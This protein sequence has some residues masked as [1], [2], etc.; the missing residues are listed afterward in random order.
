MIQNLSYDFSGNLLNSLKTLFPHPITQKMT[1]VEVGCFE[2]QGSM[3]LCKKL[4]TQSESILICIDPFDEEYV[5]GSKEM[6]FWDN[7]CKGQY[8]R[9]V[10]NTQGL[11]IKVLRGKSEE[12]IPEILDNSIDFAYIDGDHRPEE[13]YK[14]AINI[15]SKMKIGGIILFDDYLWSV[16]GIFTKPGIDKFIS[17]MGNKIQ[18]IFSSYQ[19][20]VC[21]NDYDL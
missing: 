2:G 10:Q 12:K 15:F 20:A 8:E 5:K 3:I 14:D 17:E 21:I 18:I 19:L 11:Q 4:C 13:V 16:N 6:S 9:F 7:A 1:C